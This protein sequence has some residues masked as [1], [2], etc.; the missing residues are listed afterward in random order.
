MKL[1]INKY[2]LYPLEKPK[3]KSQRR[4]L[5]PEILALLGNQ[6]RLTMGLA[7]SPQLGLK[8]ARK[9]HLK[10]AQL[11]PQWLERT[12]RWR[13]QRLVPKLAI[14]SLQRL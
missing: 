4:I 2:T 6:I 8:E 1:T 7:R 5:R 13:P 14:R 11:G 10:G 3:S 12:S 9:A